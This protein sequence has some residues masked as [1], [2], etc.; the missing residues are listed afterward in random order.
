VP[1]AS[2]GRTAD[3]LTALAQSIASPHA[4]PQLLGAAHGIAS[5][6][7]DLVRV[8]SARLQYLS[9][10]T[11]ADQIIHAV[12]SDRKIRALDRYEQRALSRRRTAVHAFHLL[13]QKIKAG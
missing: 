10:H 1:I 3:E 12:T 9:A 13:S 2:K 6:Q 7:L 8:R 4:S 11:T 5:A